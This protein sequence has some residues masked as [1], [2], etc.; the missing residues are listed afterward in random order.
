VIESDK[1]C[2]SLLLSLYLQQ[3]KI[4]EYE[5]EQ[6]FKNNSHPGCTL[7]VNNVDGMQ[8]HATKGKGCGGGCDR[9]RRGPDN[10]LVE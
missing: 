2:N 5:Q 1:I 4:K 8:R 7:P 6:S 3:E 9:Y 10:I